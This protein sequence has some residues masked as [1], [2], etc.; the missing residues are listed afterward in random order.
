[1]SRRLVW[2]VSLVAFGGRAVAEPAPAS[3]SEP[4]PAKTAAP[5]ATSTEPAAA[6][7][8]T[9]VAAAPDAAT[10]AA[11]APDAATPAPPA[12]ATSAP[13]AKPDEEQDPFAFADFTWQSGSA[14]TKDSLLGNQY[15][16]A[17]FRLD[18]VFH[19]SLNHPK[20]DTIG[21]STEA[22]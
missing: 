20:D 12:A 14:R 19:Y 22:W 3:A 4:S 18:D 9:P 6:T 21:G 16:T 7:P 1:V 15:F 13:P 10:P 2:L 8:A 11:A 17:E 5:A